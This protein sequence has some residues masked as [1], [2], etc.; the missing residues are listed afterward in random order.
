MNCGIYNEKTEILGSVKTDDKISTGIINMINCP[1]ILTG[2]S[3]EMRTHMNSIVAFSF[4]LNNTECNEKERKEFSNH[5]LSSCEQ[6][7]VLFDNFLD[8]AII[9]TGN[10]KAEPRSCNLGRFMDD[11]LSEFRVILNRDEYNE[12]VLILENQADSQYDIYIDTDRLTRVMRNLFQNALTNTRSGYIKI[13]YRL[14]DHIV[15]FFIRDSGSG[16]TKCKEFL[17]TSNLNESLSKHNDTSTAINL[18]LARK[19]VTLMN[20]EIRVENNGNTGT[21]M[22]FSIPVSKVGKVKY[23]IKKVNNINP[24]TSIAI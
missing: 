7:M 24:N 11:L 8:S 13:G 12:V 23:S 14:N 6:L 4:L 5:I 9:D 10:S 16:Y 1:T 22:L 3:H 18:T 21:A 20:G 15:E 17:Q 2:M 19:L